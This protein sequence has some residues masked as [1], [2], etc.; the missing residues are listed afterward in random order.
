MVPGEV[1]VRAKF[2]MIPD[3]LVGGKTFHVTWE[4]ILA[5]AAGILG[6]GAVLTLALGSRQRRRLIQP[7]WPLRPASPRWPFEPFEPASGRGA[8]SSSVRLS[9]IGDGQGSDEELPML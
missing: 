7:R 5:F 8:Q 6:A 9:L 2:Q 4:L 3:K 1:A